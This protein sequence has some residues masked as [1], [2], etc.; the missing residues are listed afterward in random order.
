[1]PQASDWIL[2][3]GG[4]FSMGGGLR[5]EENPAHEVELDAFLLARFPVTRAAYSTFLRTTGHE[6][7]EFW[8]EPSFRKPRA[9]AVGPSWN[10]ADAYCRW[11]D[12]ES[13]EAVR[14]PSEAEWEFA[15]R[16]G[17]DVL[18]PWGDEGAES[19]PDYDQRWLDGPEPVDAY[20]SRHPWGFL[21]LGENVHEW[22][23]DWY[24]RNYYGVSPTKNPMG[25][26][27]GRR[28]ASRGGSWR[29]DVKVTRCTARSS[30]PP[31]FRY[32]DYGF[33]LCRTAG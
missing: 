5:D 24:D 12:A 4:S 8:N 1:M 29:H 31:H 26:P 13:G 21:G 6:P 14:L 7:P 18:Y 10:D 19:V 17:R 2:V 30:I 22:C 20:P 9:P 16:A 27:S 32:A 23:R 15:A 28:R 33:R 3:E 11:Y 25:P